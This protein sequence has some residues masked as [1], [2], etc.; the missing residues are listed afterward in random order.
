MLRPCDLFVWILAVCAV[1]GCSHHKA[2]IPATSDESGFV[3]MFNGKDT[4]GWAY[5]TIANRGKAGNGYTVN[6]DI[7]SCTKEDGGVLYTEKDYANFVLRFAFK[8]TPHANNGIGIR[9]PYDLGNPS[10]LG[11]E[12]QVLDDSD[13]AYAHLRPT[14]YHGSVYD[15]VPA[16]RGHEKPVGEWNEEQITAVGSHITVTLNGFVI[17]D[18]NLTDIT[19]PHVLAK[20][21]GVR[22]TSGRVALLGHGE[23]VEFKDLRIKTL[24]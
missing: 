14:Q 1:A 15:V 11:M 10:Y 3:P 7:V 24:P 5:G 23:V 2:S 17:V 13:P 6:G 21:P 16:I 8:L 20:H 19:D 22:R 18:T 12:L 9:A 4:T